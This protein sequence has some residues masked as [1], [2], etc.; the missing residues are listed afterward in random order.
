[1]A[2]AP[3]TGPGSSSL[4][5]TVGL[6]TQLG[7]KRDPMM[8][9]VS[10]LADCCE[11]DKAELQEARASP[12]SWEVDPGMSCNTCHAAGVRGWSDPEAGFILLHIPG[13]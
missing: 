7:G 13:T 10:G 6:L 8:A 9:K 5:L 11:E 2:I 3:E 1:M 4:Q 12:H